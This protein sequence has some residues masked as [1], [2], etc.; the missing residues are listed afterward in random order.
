MIL[1]NQVPITC[2]AIGVN[3]L[4]Y[5]GKSETLSETFRVCMP[6]AAYAH[7]CR[8]KQKD[9]C[10]NVYD[11]CAFSAYPFDKFKWSHITKR[12]STVFFILSELARMYT[13]RKLDFSQLVIENL[14]LTCSI[15]FK[16][17]LLD[18]HFKLLHQE[19]INVYRQ[20]QQGEIDESLLMEGLYAFTCF[21]TGVSKAVYD[22]MPL[23]AFCFKKMNRFTFCS[24]NKALNECEDLSQSKY[25]DTAEQNQIMKHF[26]RLDYLL[27]FASGGCDIKHMGDGFKTVVIATT[28]NELVD[29]V[30]LT[31]FKSQV[32]EA[33][34]QMNVEDTIETDW[35]TINTNNRKSIVYLQEQVEKKIGKN[36]RVHI[37]V[38]LKWIFLRSLLANLT[39]DGNEHILLSFQK[40]SNWA[41]KLE[42]N[43]TEI[44]RFLTTFTEIGSLLYC[45][46]YDSLS[47]FVIVD[48]EAF[49]LL[50]DTLYHPHPN[51]DTNGWI[52]KY[53]I[54][55]VDA[56][57]SI[58]GDISINVMDILVSLELAVNLSPDQVIINGEYCSQ[59]SH[60]MPNI[61]AG[62]RDTTVK[63]GSLMLRFLTPTKS[64][65][66]ATLSKSILSRHPS[67][68]IK[69]IATENVNCTKLR[70]NL[71][72]Q[73]SF[74]IHILYH[75][76]EFELRLVN[77]PRESP[78]STNSIISTCTAIIEGFCR[79]ML[80]EA[81]FK[82]GVDFS[83][84]FKCLEKQGVYHQSAD[85][86]ECESFQSMLNADEKNDIQW[87]IAAL[88]KV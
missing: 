64:E 85:I 21:D 75:A 49:V 52:S 83:I 81:N 57:K 53:G 25:K 63:K 88:K 65:N 15:S 33:A 72:E 40:I 2:C 14:D 76:K 1:V 18:E 41:S 59:K 51:H 61:R 66:E 69:L 50:L 47:K 36:K 34:K 20:I 46:V 84:E 70:I 87:W 16:D 3:G 37:S 80:H 28:K 86:M 79:G 43:T 73:T 22:I 39:F 31:Q 74:E 55:T 27:R 7:M 54:V 12:F 23:F 45:P 32:S 82:R 5:S 62:D 78:P 38:P 24:L 17:K 67:S 30:R 9:R 29:Q 44:E 58:F 10:L 56:A 8:E 68:K 11:I 19:C 71:D 6:D 4:P 77:I 26:P 13:L 35:V 48:I 42:M 60:F